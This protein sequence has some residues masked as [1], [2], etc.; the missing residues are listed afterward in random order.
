[1]CLYATPLIHPKHLHTYPQTNKTKTGRRDLCAALAACHR[2]RS[3]C[4]QDALWAPSLQALYQA[5][6]GKRQ[7]EAH[8]STFGR[9]LHPDGPPPLPVSCPRGG[10]Q[11][12]AVLAYR[13]RC[14]ADAGVLLVGPR[15]PERYWLKCVGAC[16]VYM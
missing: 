6:H 11:S 15:W 7:I 5:W 10:S 3:L 12:R 2:F 14:A 9:V 1:M 4:L 16:W 8:L 13:G